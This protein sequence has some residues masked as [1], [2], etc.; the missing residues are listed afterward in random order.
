MLRLQDG[1]G[2][3]PM[4]HDMLGFCSQDRAMTRDQLLLTFK[5]QGVG[6]TTLDRLMDGNAVLRGVAV[7]E[8]VQ[9]KGYGRALG[10][11]VERFAAAHAVARLCVNADPGKVGYYAGLGFK[12]GRVG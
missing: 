6:I 11:L 1:A 7:D 8:A 5:N 2:Y 9:G 3:E 12:A 10:A 4:L